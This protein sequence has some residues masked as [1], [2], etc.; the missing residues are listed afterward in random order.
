MLGSAHAGPRHAM[1]HTSYHMAMV[2]LREGKGQ[3]LDVKV[4]ARAVRIIG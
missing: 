1:V 2:G 4:Q 3:K